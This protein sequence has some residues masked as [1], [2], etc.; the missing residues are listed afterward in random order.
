MI[1]DKNT[2]FFQITDNFAKT[3]HI[4]FVTIFE[5]KLDFVPKVT[6]AI[7]TFRRAVL[8]KE[9][10][11][12]AINQKYFNDY[13]IIIVDN[14]PERDCET[15]I[16]LK[17]Y[18]DPR[19]SYYKNSENIGMF[20]NWN[21]C[22][23]LSK[24][25]YLTILNDDDLLHPSYLNNVMKIIISNHLDGLF[26]RFSSFRDNDIPIFEE[27]NNISFKK[28]TFIDNLYENTNAGSLGAIVKKNN[29]I[30]LG[31][32]NELFYP[33]ADYVLWVNY[34]KKYGSIYRINEELAYYRLSVNESLNVN[35]HSTFIKNDLILLDQMINILPPFYKKIAESAKPVLIYGKYLGMCNF[36]NQFGAKNTNEINIL[37]SQQTFKSM[38]FYRLLGILNRTSEI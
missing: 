3:A 28:N 37:K 13:D 6:I 10:L 32:F 17:S 24:G 27:Y 36:S 33:T 15:E 29:L 25:D 23:E 21:R 20:G 34:I 30:E 18:L 9:A 16:M 8:L 31:G 38:F 1:I 5:S 19:L 35:L 12:S 26:V 4:P 7:P 22:I 2:N 11:D 14:N